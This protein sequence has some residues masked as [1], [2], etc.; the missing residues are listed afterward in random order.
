MTSSA[1]GFGESPGVPEPSR[2]A[3][4]PVP[5]AVAVVGYFFAPPIGERVVRSYRLI[6]WFLTTMLALVPSGAESQER[7]QDRARP[8]LSRILGAPPMMA[9]D[10]II[11]EIVERLDFDNYKRLTQG[12]ATFGDRR[13][14]SEAN[15][16]AVDWI[17]EQL[18]SWGYAPERHV[19]F[20]PTGVQV[21]A[22]KTGRSTPGEMYIL[23]AHMDGTGGGDA[24]NDNASGTA[25]VLEIARI[26]AAPDI[27][28]ERSVRFIFWNGEE[29]G[30]EG[31]RAYVAERAP[32]Q[33]VEDPVGSRHYPEPRWLGMIQHDKVLFDHGT[34]AGMQQS[35]N[36]DIDIE[37]QL[38]STQW[39]AS[40]QLALTL[41]NS[42]RLFATDYPATVSN[43]MHATDSNAFMNSVA[44]VSVRE[45]RRRYEMAQGSDPHWHRPSDVL[46]TYSEADF[47]FGFNAMQTTLAAV[48]QL[49]GAELVT[50]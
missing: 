24:V 41:L 21:Y 42:N 18:R 3:G 14:G 1:P 38:A 25:L 11:R 36:A 30:L 37:Y 44:A 5:S 9:G 26:L 28:V 31:S 43:E 39:W 17:D 13:H 34:P 49:A 40:A 4:A 8:P 47:R 48:V 22:T 29:T 50:K 23:G 12:L 19:Y 20:V 33:G 27:Q 15:L 10:S 16:G 6:L 2:S 46:E 35:V 7:P 32:L 45:N